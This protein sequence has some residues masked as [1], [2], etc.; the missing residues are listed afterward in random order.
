[1]ANH[2][3]KT[4]MEYADA[5]CEHKRMVDIREHSKH[6]KVGD[7]IRY[8]P[9]YNQ[10]PVKGHP[11]TSKKWGVVYVDEHDPRVRKDYD[12]ICVVEIVPQWE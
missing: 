9:Y 2:D 12:L 8:T 4:T 1:M 6:I 7:I 5:M 10:K 3:L 11:M